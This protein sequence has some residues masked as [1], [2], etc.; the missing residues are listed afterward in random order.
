MG[1]GLRSWLSLLLALEDGANG[2]VLVDEIENG[3]HYSVHAR[4][5]QAIA[6]TARELDCQVFVTTHSYE[7]VRHAHEALADSDH[8]EDFR[9]MRLDRTPE[10]IVPVLYGNDVLAAAIETGCEVR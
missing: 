3:L 5:W 6:Q 7:F 1:E 4:I 10:G 8:A 9:Y 2:V